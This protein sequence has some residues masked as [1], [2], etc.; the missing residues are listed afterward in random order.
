MMSFSVPSG[1]ATDEIPQQRV[2]MEDRLVCGAL[3]TSYRTRGAK[4][5]PDL[6]PSP[7][8]DVRTRAAAHIQQGRIFVRAFYGVARI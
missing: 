6:H 7:A 8:L 4:A 3:P 2:A 1:T 5:P